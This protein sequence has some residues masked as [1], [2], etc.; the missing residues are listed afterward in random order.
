MTA[1]ASSTE[2]MVPGSARQVSRPQRVRDVR[3]AVV[4]E[5]RSWIGTPYHDQASMK[6]AGCDCL[7]LVRGVWRAVIGPEPERL[8]P[9]T[10]DWRS[11]ESREPLI[12]AARRHFVEVPVVEAGS[13][14]VVA[15]RMRAGHA[16][17]HCGILSGPDR[18]IHAQ[19]GLPVAEVNLGSWWRRRIVAAFRF[20]CID[21]AR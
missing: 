16:A 8:P 1:A 10:H 9:Y 12:A 19:E 6:G 15:F 13:G 11:K 3:E 17:K 7:G 2:Q 5:A 14:D 21:G 18:F 4:A 20:P